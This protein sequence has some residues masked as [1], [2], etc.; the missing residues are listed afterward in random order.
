M[1]LPPNHSQTYSKLLT[2][3][4]PYSILHQCYEIEDLKENLP[5]SAAYVVLQLSDDEQY[6]FCG[7]MQVSRERRISYYCTKLSLASEDR[8]IND[9][10]YN[11]ACVLA[12]TGE[13]DGALEQLRL[14]ITRDPE[15]AQHIDGNP[16]FSNIAQEPG[17]EAIVNH[18]D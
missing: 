1:L 9:A 2:Q 17:F 12:M 11:M 4:K 6:L 3:S 14:L 8:E 15:W 10:L 13:T 18:A 16:Y 7:V 5:H